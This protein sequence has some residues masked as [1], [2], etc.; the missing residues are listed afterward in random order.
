MGKP[1]AANRDDCDDEDIK[2]KGHK[3]QRSGATRLVI[4]G[5]SKNKHTHLVR[6]LEDRLLR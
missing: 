4:G 6:T 2:G 5:W 1:T 3:Q